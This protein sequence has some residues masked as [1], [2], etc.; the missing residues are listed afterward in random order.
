MFDPN[1]RS[2]IGRYRIMSIVAIASW[3]LFRVCQKVNSSAVPAMPAVPEPTEMEDEEEKP[4][5]KKHKSRPV[6]PVP[7]SSKSSSKPNKSRGRED[8]KSGGEISGAQFNLLL[9]D[10]GAIRQSLATIAK[11]LHA[12]AAFASSSGVAESLVKLKA[13]RVK[14]LAK[15]PNL[16]TIVVQAGKLEESGDEEEDDT[17]TDSRM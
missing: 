15:V 14:S 3:L 8:S 10:V 6:S 13:D 16:V 5:S 4:A 2:S 17:K 11:S 9:N 12:I 7:K 1:I